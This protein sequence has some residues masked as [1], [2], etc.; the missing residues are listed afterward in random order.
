[1]KAI[2]KLSALAL[3]AA[4]M[5]VSC[6]VETYTP[7]EIVTND[8]VRTFTCVFAP[9]DSKVAIAETG[10]TTWEAGDEILVHA[11][12]FGNERKVVTLTPDMI[13]ADGKKATITVT[14]LKPAVIGSP[15]QNSYFAQYPASASYDGDLYFYS[16]FSNTDA[17]LMGACDYNGE[18][19]FFNLCGVIAYK[20]SGD[21]DKVVFKGNCD[22]TVAY[23][24]YQARIVSTGGEP[25]CAYGV[26][27]NNVDP[28]PLSVVEKDVVADGSTLNYIFLP[29]GA[30]FYSG[31]TFSFYKDG[32]L[33]KE[34]VTQ[35][36]VNVPH[37]YLL[38][39]GDITDHVEEFVEI[40]TISE[41]A[42]APV[43]T[44]V[45]ISEAHVYAVAE[46]GFVV[47]MS[48][49]P[50]LFVKYDGGDIQETDIVSIVADK[51]YAEELGCN[52]LGGNVI[53]TKR[54]T[55]SL[56]GYDYPD[57][58][59]ADMEA[60]GTNVE[61]VSVRGMLDELEGLFH[62][63]TLDISKMA[64]AEV[65]IGGFALGYD[66]TAGCSHIVPAWIQVLDLPVLSTIADVN[67][68][69]NGD[70]FKLKGQV[71]EITDASW[72]GSFKIKD[73]DGNTV[74]INETVDEFGDILY[75]QGGLASLG[76]EVNKVV[77]LVGR[78]DVD[79]TVYNPR[80]R[81]VFVLEVEDGPEPED[82]N[83]L[84]AVDLG[85]SVKWAN[86]NLGAV[87]PGHRGDF[88]AWGDPE[89]YFTYTGINEY[90][91]ETGYEYREGK[92]EGYQFSNYK[93]WE[94]NGEMN[95]DYKPIQI[96]ILKYNTRGE[97]GTV[98][99]K[100]VLQL[101]DDA[102]HVNLGEKWR[103]PTREEFQELLDN[104][105]V[106]LASF[107]TGHEYGAFQFTSTINGNSIILPFNYIDAVI[108]TIGYE[109][110]ANYWTSSLCE[111]FEEVSG[112]KYYDES[113]WY[114]EM[115]WGQDEYLVN[116]IVMPGT[117]NGARILATYRSSGHNVRAVWDD[118]L[119]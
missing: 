75:F 98:D 55:G 29:G 35:T 116:G 14:G 21:F 107:S 68:G 51:V 85:L 57:Y 95:T 115:T 70:Y 41:A 11:G 106:E 17:F 100:T 24:I 38:S 56:V 22:E 45:K 80:L 91:Y 12:V 66:Q 71:Y 102:A 8:D 3:A 78:R 83:V 114:L 4:A 49:Q 50:F 34:A 7:D 63:S 42:E 39:L 97:W 117:E 87:D 111:F 48:S 54:G 36:P 76:V 88:F 15:V 9:V 40:Y 27:E 53:V 28:S 20:V 118:T 37:G 18:F 65:R 119:E 59:L 92:E 26:S 62:M 16:R 67:A 81:D 74:P 84:R 79:N 5:M 43:G 32:E 31:F 110:G 46:D 93:W 64:G 47:S 44:R 113:A 58:A 94:W 104:C 96:N 30:S 13:S 52:V 99:K 112:F 25:R 61:P 90:G 89:P 82:P 6:Q 109:M 105:T 73:E 10:K 69:Q 103:M 77:T 33:V 72:Y 19:S 86:M 23:D 108:S 60:F 1:M 2:M 101:E